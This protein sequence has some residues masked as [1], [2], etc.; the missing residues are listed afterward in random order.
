MYPE[1]PGIE[2]RI[3]SVIASTAIANKM[4]LNDLK[5]T[6]FRSIIVSPLNYY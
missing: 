3:G 4:F 2:S 6:E 5:I 1:K